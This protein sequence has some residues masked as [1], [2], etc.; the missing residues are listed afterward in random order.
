MK[1]QDE[2]KTFEMLPVPK[3]RGRP[4]TGKAKTG[5]ER[6]K[7]YRERHPQATVRQLFEALKTLPAHME[8]LEAKYPTSDRNEQM[9]YRY[10]Y[11]MGNLQEFL[12]RNGIASE[13]TEIWAAA[14]LDR[15]R[16]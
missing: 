13:E 15:A 1:D 7:Q 14:M 6:Q 5:A 12:M 3:K 10:A 8:A 4:A 16:T 2:Q 11:M 9:R